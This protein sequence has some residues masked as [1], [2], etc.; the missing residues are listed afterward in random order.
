MMLL[1]ALQLPSSDTLALTLEAARTRALEANPTL[2]AER[3]EARAAA[4]ASREASRAFLPT[5]ST[6]LRGVRSTDPVAAFGMKLRQ[7]RFTASDLSLDAL[8]RPSPVGDYTA[9]LSIEQ[10]LFAPEGWYAHAAASR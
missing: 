5:I 3:A 6:E 7:E 4:Q 10:P 1:L 2:R 8:N 9:R